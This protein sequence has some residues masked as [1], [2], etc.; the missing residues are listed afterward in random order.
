MR[1]LISLRSLQR[2]INSIFKFAQLPLSCSHCTCISKRTKTVSVTFK[3]KNKGS[4]QHLT[5][6]STGLK[7]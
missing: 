2:F 1:T 7:I 5:I 4:T 6:D 3:T